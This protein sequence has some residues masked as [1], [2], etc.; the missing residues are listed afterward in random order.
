MER[1]LEACVVYRA[2]EREFPDRWGRLIDAGILSP[3]ESWAFDCGLTGCAGPAAIVD[4]AD[5]YMVKDSDFTLLTLCG[6][7]AR[8]PL[9]MLKCSQER[10]MVG[11]S[12]GTVEDG[13]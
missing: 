7:A 13:R 1:L 10:N 11:Y 5:G 12:D 8:L 6:E 3:Y 9:V 2:G 4:T